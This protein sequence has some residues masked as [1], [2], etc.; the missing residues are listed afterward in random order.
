[1][2]HTFTYPFEAAR[3][4]GTVIEVQPSYVRINLP[5]A[6]TVG[7]IQQHGDRVALGEVGEFVFLDAGERAI[8]G[9]IL[10]IRLPERDRLTVERPL[11]GDMTI[12]PVARVQML[13]SF[14]VEEPRQGKDRKLDGI[15]R[16]PRLGA[17][18]YSA[19]PKLMA[20]VAQ[21]AQRSEDPETRSVQLG[22]IPA[23][24]DLAFQIAP[25]RLAG[26]HAAIL[27]TTGG[28]KSWTVAKIC[29]ELATRFDRSKIIVVDPTGEYWTLPESSTM[30]R[31]IGLA[32][33]PPV[34]GD[35][36]Q[37]DGS[38][39]L[40]FCFPYT[41]LT[42]NDL[43]AIFR[44]A[45]GTQTPKLRW[46]IKSLK[47]ARAISSRRNTLPSEQQTLVKNG[48]IDKA[49]ASKRD[50]F[51]AYN[52]LAQEVEN[53]G[54]LFDVSRLPRQIEFECVFPSHRKSGVEDH[55]R[56]GLRSDSDLAYCNTLISRV[57]SYLVEP[58]FDCM[59]KPGAKDTFDAVLD[60]FLRSNSKR[61]LRL[62][63]SMVPG[64][65]NVREILA[66]AIA[67]TLMGRA[68]PGRFREQP[69]VVV[70]DEAHQFLSR[71]LGEDDWTHKLDAF[72]V[73]AKEGRKYGLT[74]VVAT[75][76][77]RDIPEG[78][79][80]QMGCLIVHRLI[81]DADL[82]VVERACGEI[83]RAASAF[84]PVLGPG[85]AVVVGVDVPFPL[86]VQVTP[87]STPPRSAGPDYQTHWR[88]R[89]PE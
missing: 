10:E 69:V 60:T 82:K 18:A 58:S 31:W 12:H 65:E 61:I 76:R 80:S 83:D 17:R 45:K 86:S 50:Y 28:G 29:E 7:G 72:D 54:A 40:E 68:R 4:I 30:H 46:A 64:F 88:L 13:V 81:N 5:G 57:S 43:F 85:E 89:A 24:G 23:T 87:P 2:S 78:V 71:S 33:Y 66:N 37:F 1:M 21:C 38:P 74:I 84:L 3:Q 16:Y 41:D 52:A 9:R 56:W 26:R 70:L 48:C 6:A 19:S 27:G 34:A 25:E 14:L 20:W 73:I 59:F 55:M 11:E 53:Q 75:Q 32:E 77:P 49:G 39:R 79:L 44:P 42:E 15:A 22:T 8:L 62:C 35:A 47:L 36:N 67:R 51:E 63:L